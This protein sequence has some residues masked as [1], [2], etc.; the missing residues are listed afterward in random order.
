MKLGVINI[1]DMKIKKCNKKGDHRACLRVTWL[2][3][4]GI[5]TGYGLKNLNRLD[6][7]SSLGYLEDAQFYLGSKAS[8]IVLLHLSCE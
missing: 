4:W 5:F 2:L 1:P 8:F 7:E 3:K 6:T